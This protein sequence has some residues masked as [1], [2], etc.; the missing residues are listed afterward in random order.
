MAW[1]LFKIGMLVRNGYLR[2]RSA[3]PFLSFSFIA[4]FLILRTIL[5]KLVLPRLGFSG[6]MPAA[7]ALLRACGTAG[8]AYAGQRGLLGEDGG[9]ALVSRA[10]AVTDAAAAA[11]ASVVAAVAHGVGVQPETLAGGGAGVLGQGRGSALLVGAVGALA[12]REA[13]S[14]GWSYVASL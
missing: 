12:L 10:S 13:A 4:N 8:A 2:L 3:L 9:A 14:A 11:R 1:Q 7:A 5:T 6:M